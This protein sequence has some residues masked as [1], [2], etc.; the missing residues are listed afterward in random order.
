MNPRLNFLSF[1]TASLL[2]CSQFFVCAVS[3]QQT[4]SPL[5]S[6]EATRGV[7]LLSQGDIKGA[8]K[9]LQSATKHHRDDAT[10][11]Y[12]LGLAYNRDGNL[13]Q[14][15]SAFENSIRLQ[16]NLA[17]PYVGLAYIMLLKNQ[18]QPALREAKFALTLDG[19]NAEAHYIISAVYMKEQS[20]PQALEEVET[21]LKLNSS[22]PAAFLL[23]SQIL[24]AM[25]PKKIAF[26]EGD[27]AETRQLRRREAT[28]LLKNAAESLER[29]LQLDPT[30]PSAKLWREQLETLHVYSQSDA[31]DDATRTVFTSLEV[32]T[33]AR[34]LTKPE[35]QYTTSARLGQVSGTVVLRA[36][37]ASDGTV[38][39]ILVIQSL[40]YGLTEQAILAAR[41]IKFEPATIDGRPVSQFIQIEYNFSV[42]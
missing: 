17:G 33:R 18:T 36:V 15:R 23:K 9:A 13:K 24:V 27:S 40:P 42:F 34:I 37:L 20:L 41:K 29:Y 3:A 5:V 31:D 21:A 14:A 16:P 10:A 19:Q 25:Y 2:L 32:T 39:H 1:I 22:F 6:E 38:K 11:W 4:A 28:L 12:Y 30:T 35:A 8:I 26:V 7:A